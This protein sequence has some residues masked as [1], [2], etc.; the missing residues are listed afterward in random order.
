MIKN[1][2][3]DIPVTILVI[4]VFAICSLAIF[5]FMNSNIL[6]KKDSLGIGLFEEIHS[7]VEKFYFYLSVGDSKEAA[8]EKINASINKS[9]LII[10]RS[11]EIILIKYTKEIINLK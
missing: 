10:E 3:A 4:G 5:S 7:D 8:A 9:Q 11:N 1:K 6:G 2:K